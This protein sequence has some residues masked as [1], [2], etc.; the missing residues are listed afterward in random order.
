MIRRRPQPK[1]DEQI[2]YEC[3]A[4]EG[5]HGDLASRVARRVTN[6]PPGRENHPGDGEGH[7]REKPGGGAREGLTSPNVLL[8][9]HEKGV[10]RF[11]SRLG[12]TMQFYERLEKGRDTPCREQNQV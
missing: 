9:R 6:G 2:L 3:I 11:P 10:S 7:L 8:R 5:S 4:S 1:S 12:I